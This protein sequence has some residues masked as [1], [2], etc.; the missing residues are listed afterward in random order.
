MTC[1]KCEKETY[2]KGMCKNHYALDYYHKRTKNPRPVN[3]N[4]KNYNGHTNSYDTLHSRVRNARGKASL[5]ECVDCQ[6][7]A[8]DWA[9]MHDAPGKR[10]LSGGRYDGAWVSD[11]VNDYEPRCKDCHRAYDAMHQ[12]KRAYTYG[13]AA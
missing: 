10:Q 7:Q 4:H 13:R 5:Y 8:S 1:N 9:L 12:N 2:C 11:D 6:G 3:P